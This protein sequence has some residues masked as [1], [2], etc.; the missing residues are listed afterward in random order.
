MKIVQQLHS[1]FD[2]LPPFIFSVL[3]QLKRE[4]PLS[5]DETFNIRLALEESLTNAV[6][7]GNK[8]NPELMVDV[9]IDYQNGCLKVIVKD[10]GPGFDFNNVP[11]PTLKERRVLISGRGIFLIKKIMD[12]IDFSDG[13]RQIQMIKSLS[14]N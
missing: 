12:R 13:G 1:C 2:H 7:H 5:E 14:K 3:D 4:V 10:Q 9:D 8:F 6:K 11:D